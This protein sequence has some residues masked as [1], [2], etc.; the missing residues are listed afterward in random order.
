[1]STRWRKIWREFVF[2]Q[3]RFLLL[4]LAL[5][6]AMTAMSG[7]LSARE[8]LTYSMRTNFAA[9][10][11]A[12]AQLRVDDLDADLLATVRGMPQVADADLLAHA[13]GRT[14]TGKDRLR[15]LLLFLRGDTLPTLS[16]FE[17]RDGEWPPRDNGVLIE[18]SARRVLGADDGANFEAIFGNDQTITLR[19]AG[20]V[21]DAAQAPASQEGMVYAYTTFANAAALGIVVKPEWLLLRCDGAADVETIR[22]C[23]VGVAKRLKAA[24]HAVRE[25]RI[26]PPG[27]HPHESQMQAALRLLLG[28]GL[29]ALVLAAVLCAAVVGGLLAQ[30]SRAIAVQQA[31]GATP[32]QLAVPYLALVATLALIAGMVGLFLGYG[33]GLHLAMHSA[34]HLNLR[35]IATG[36]P[37]AASAISLLIG[38]ALPVLAAAVPIFAAARRPVRAALDDHGIASPRDT[39]RTR[40]SGG[41]RFAG[42]PALTLA[43]RNLQRR[44]LRLIL[45]LAML[46]IAGALFLANTNLRAGW[47]TIMAQAAQQWHFD[48]RVA[49]AGSASL[50]DVKRAL[51]A[52]PGL[53]GVESWPS[54]MVSVDDHDDDVFVT[55]AHADGGHGAVRLRAVPDGSDFLALTIEQGRWLRSGDTQAV[56]LNSVAATSTF[57]GTRIGD[58]IDVRSADGHLHAQVI[59]I[60]REVMSG[61]SLYTTTAAFTSAAPYDPEQIDSLRLAYVD[62]AARDASLVR[63]TLE[64][65]GIAVAAVIDNADVGESQWEHLGILL[66]VL[67]A[68]AAVM[69]VVGLAGLAAAASAAV[70]DRRRELGVLAA[71]GATPALILRSVLY[72]GVFAAAL[73]L[74]IALPLSL[75]AAAVIAPLLGNL[76]G[77]PL[78][79]R[80]SATGSL[81]WCALVLPAAALACWLPARAAAKLSVVEAIRRV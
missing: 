45:N 30:Q 65:A 57:A 22:T 54:T 68:V 27:L 28:F 50:E 23:A 44:R 77:A 13:Y 6:L 17:I 33:V 41:T 64:K 29:L 12:S 39:Q 3:D 10:H 25:V 79:L 8:T 80:L 46:G 81:L 59:G 14:R 51:A 18:R 66:F 11:A 72:E 31:I 76:A 5:A 38:I 53:R 34:Q 9:T 36:L 24:G 7:L 26:P 71:I 32:W 70:I 75:A 42:A 20:T 16:T 1:M 60:A 62:G 55:G 21:H 47:H 2:A 56:V 74:A 40:R 19:N 67:R 52:V 73:S 4:S 58:W 69:A 63:T 49:L 35:I 61:A 78:P 15:P 48:Q 37:L 43:W